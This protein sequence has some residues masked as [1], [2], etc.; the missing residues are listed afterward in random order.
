MLEGMRVAL[1]GV[2]LQGGWVVRQISRSNK[3]DG[4]WPGHIG[5]SRCEPA[6]SINSYLRT[7]NARIRSCEPL[8]IP[9]AWPRSTQNGPL[10]PL[11]SGRPCENLRFGRVR[12]ST[13]RRTCDG[14]RGQSCIAVLMGR[15]TEIRVP[16]GAIV[17]TVCNCCSII[18][19]RR[20]CCYFSQNTSRWKRCSRVRH[21][22]RQA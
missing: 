4:G 14:I 15:L 22:L 20:V 8:P 10:S 11:R 9:F 6:C 7:S 2:T 5:C 16:V 18:V 3:Y 21:A 12:A 1:Q 19:V 17:R 13:Y